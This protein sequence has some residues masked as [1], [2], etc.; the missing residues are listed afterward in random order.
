MKVDLEQ[1]KKPCSCGRTHDIS[2]EEI[3]IESGAAALL[4]RWIEKKNYRKPVMVCDENTYEAAGKTVAAML[5][6]IGIICLDPKGLHAD[7]RAVALVAEKLTECDVLVAVGA[8]TVHDATRYTAHERGVPFISVPTAASV[9]GFVSTVAAMTWYG[10]KKTMPAV[11]PEAVFADT[12]IFSKAPVRLSASGF[13]DLLGKYTALIDWKAGHLLT[14][15]YFCDT[16]CGMEL[17]A[18]RIVSENLDGIR[19]GDAYACEQ[20]M[21]GLIL[22]G[23]A[24]QMIGNSRPAS[25]AEHHL[26]HLWEMEAV[27]THV[28]AYH[29]EKVGVGLKIAADIYHRFADYLESSD[30][31]LSDYKGVE[32]E[33]LTY[34]ADPDVKKQIEEENAVDPLADIDRAVLSCK[35]GELAKLLRKVPAGEEIAM[36][37]KKA[38]APAAMEDI[39]LSEELVPLSAR[40]SP[41]VRRRLTCMRLI[42]LT[43]F[44]L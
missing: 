11:A 15:E 22:S 32:T 12:D 14:G 42:K 21:Y 43:D 30:F 9:D 20:L 6:G 1:L 8:G 31:A 18:V 16:I 27:N 44:V 7:E 23:L 38:G 29:G 26:S 2:V 4:P 37:L 34:F 17:D 39:G 25:G 41:Y 40:L 19:T 13:G 36:L 5:P 24:M 35:S 28:D 3:R 33:L 10:Y